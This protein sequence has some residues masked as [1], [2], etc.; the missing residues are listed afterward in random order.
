MGTYEAKDGKL[1][2]V[3]GKT[4]FSSLIRKR[5]LL[6]IDELRGKVNGIHD[7]FAEKKS[8]LEEIKACEAELEK[9]PLFFTELEDTVLPIPER[10]AR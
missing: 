2:A 6:D 10:S 1:E 9:I 8:A 5:L 7:K 4:L 3:F